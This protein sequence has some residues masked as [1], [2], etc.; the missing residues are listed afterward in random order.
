MKK[1]LTSLMLVVLMALMT[2]SSVAAQK[3]KLNVKG[4]VISFE[5]NVLMIMSNKG[6]TIEIV[7]PESFTMP[8][9]ASGDSVLVKAGRRRGG[10]MDRRDR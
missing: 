3:D 6:E 7:I 8:E 1:T 5:G 10:R 2:F 4:E 9:L